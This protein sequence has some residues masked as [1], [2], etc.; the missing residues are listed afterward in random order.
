MVNQHF[1]I[2]NEKGISLFFGLPL[3]GSFLAK[4]PRSISYAI[5]KILD[6]LARP[7]LALADVI[8]IQCTPISKPERKSSNGVN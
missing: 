4:L 1:E 8:L 3:W 6:K 2:K 7:F 5:L